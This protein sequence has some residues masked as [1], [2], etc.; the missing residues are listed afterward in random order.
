LASKS[1]TTWELQT[2]PGFLYQWP[3][4][5]VLAL[6]IAG[7][8]GFALVMLELVR[9]LLPR[10]GFA[11]HHAHFGGAMIH[12]MMVIYGLVAALIAVNVYETYSD[13]SRTVSREATAISA[14]YRDAGGYPEPTHSW[15]QSAI[16][17][18]TLQIINEAWPQQRRGQT[19]SHGVVMMNQI[20]QALF[21]FEPKFEGQKILHAE[22][23]RAFNELALARRLRV[24]A[25]RERLPSVMWRLLIFGAL[26]CLF[27]ACFFHLDDP[28]LHKLS[29]AMLATLMALVLFMIFAWD[30]PY[31]GEFGIDSDAYRLVYEQLMHQ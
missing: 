16:R 19:P 21:S 28:R 4:W 27:A 25:N 26:L 13:V 9:R 31:L 29:L 22:T 11:G 14:L 10:L 30:R 1:T 5:I 12:S 2:M 24:D 23:L 3:L 17:D 15:V 8:V 7:L 18:Y 6:M 20:Q